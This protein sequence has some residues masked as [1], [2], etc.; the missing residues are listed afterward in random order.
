MA[1]NSM[2]GYGSGAAASRALRVEVELGSVNRR[3]LDVRL[4]LPRTLAALEPRVH[5]IIHQRVARGS[6][7]GSVRISDMSAAGRRVRLDIDAAREYVKAL[8][9]AA[10]DL[11][12]PDDITARA[13][14]TLPDIMRYDTPADDPETVWPLIERAL[15]QAMRGLLAMRCEEGKAL[16]E[17]LERRIGKLGTRRDRILALAPRVG[18][19]YRARL[20]ARLED[21]GLSISGREP[22]L[23]REVA[24]L[25]DR[26]DITEELTRLDSHLKQA[27]TKIRQGGRV[28]RT[29][30]FICQELLRE[31]NTIGSKSGDAAIS[32]QV[33]HFKAELERVREQVQNVE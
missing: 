9:K 4:S 25:A 24:L 32:G 31:I 33:I 28:G 11:D 26:S 5:E 16:Q 30:D 22:E 27:A 29:L 23:M 18:Q 6:V 19:R 3:Q 21:A 20:K 12:V 7:S 13:L 8:R 2:T 10:K 14:I 1:M 15:K 17:D